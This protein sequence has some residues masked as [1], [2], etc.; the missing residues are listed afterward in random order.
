M[1]WTKDAKQ[2]EQQA[3]PAVGVSLSASIV[4]VCTYPREPS[5]AASTCWVRQSASHIPPGGTWESSTGSVS[6]SLTVENLAEILSPEP[7]ASHT[8]SVTKILSSGPKYKHQGLGQLW[9][10]TSYSE[11]KPHIFCLCHQIKSSHRSENILHCG[12]RSYFRRLADLV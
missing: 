12:Y 5:R 1:E 6:Q 9:P 11:K 10:K 3:H 4:P 2:P 8:K 7:I